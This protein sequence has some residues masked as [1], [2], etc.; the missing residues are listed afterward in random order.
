MFE[1]QQLEGNWP[2]LNVRVHFE[3]DRFVS[4]EKKRPSKRFVRFAW[5]ASVMAG[6]STYGCNKVK[7]VGPACVTTGF[8]PLHL[9]FQS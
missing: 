1:E 9:Q 8:G 6:I 2:R 5:W 3:V 7:A 4:E